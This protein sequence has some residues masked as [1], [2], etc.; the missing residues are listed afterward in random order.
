M[1]H[2]NES[3]TETGSMKPTLRRELIKMMAKLAEIFEGEL[4]LQLPKVVSFY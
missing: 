2:I 1:Y 3:F 4:L